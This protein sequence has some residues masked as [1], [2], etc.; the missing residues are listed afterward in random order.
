M[1]GRAALAVVAVVL[2]G[3]AIVEEYRADGTLAMRRVGIAPVVVAPGRDVAAV[4]VRAMGAMYAAGH[5]VLGYSDLTL[6][7]PPQDCFAF[8]FVNDAREALRWAAL[9][10]DIQRTCERN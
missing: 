9:A 5:A 1:I 6:I 8:I 10:N 2:A 7:K 4:R 3:C